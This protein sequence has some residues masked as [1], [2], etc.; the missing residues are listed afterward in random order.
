MKRKKRKEG[1]PQ[2]SVG[3]CSMA[4]AVSSAARTVIIVKGS[5]RGEA[6]L[7]LRQS[8]PTVPGSKAGQTGA[9]VGV[10]MDW[11]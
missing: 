11:V 8:L 5:I 9:L 10:E 1:E 6:I 3:S 4:I 7:Q 2:W